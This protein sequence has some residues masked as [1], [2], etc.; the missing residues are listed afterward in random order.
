MARPQRQRR[1]AAAPAFLDVMEALIE[2][3][4]L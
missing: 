4:E 1:V 2:R 3:M